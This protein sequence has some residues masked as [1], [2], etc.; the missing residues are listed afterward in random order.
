M[1]VSKNSKIIKKLLQELAMILLGQ[2]NTTF[3]S[4]KIVK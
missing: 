4:V 3:L 1:V 2:D